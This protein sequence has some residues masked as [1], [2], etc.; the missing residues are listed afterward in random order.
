MLR[1][2]VRIWL[3]VR[4]MVRLSFCSLLSVEANEVADSPDER[5]QAHELPAEH[6]LREPATAEP[7]ISNPTDAH[8]NF[9]CTSQ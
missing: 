7:A 2:Y 9:S 5:T 1:K 6:A 3:V 8:G 4:L